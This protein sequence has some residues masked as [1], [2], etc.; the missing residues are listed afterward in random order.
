MRC[1][2]HLLLESTVAGLPAL[3]LLAPTGCGPAVPMSTVSVPDDD[4]EMAQAIAAA[5]ATM[6]KLD[7]AL[8]ARSARCYVKAAFPTPDGDDEVCWILV[9]EKR[10][11]VYHGTLDVIPERLPGLSAGSPVRVPSADAIDWMIVVRG[12]P[13]DG[14][15]TLRVLL[16]RM[17]AEQAAAAKRAMGWE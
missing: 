12:M 13:V 9:E 17:N 2:A 4:P 7:A 8:A 3:G 5:V 16:P 15:H 10:D 1:L 11:G 14:N 6:P